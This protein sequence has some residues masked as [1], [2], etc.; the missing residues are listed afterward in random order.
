MS[1]RREVVI[2]SARDGSRV[3]ASILLLIHGRS[4]TYQAGWTSDDGRRT[5]CHNLLLWKGIQLLKSRG[6]L[7]L[8]LG[9]INA[10]HAAGVTK[11]KLGM[12]GTTTKLCGQ[13]S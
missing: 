2:L 3:L 12:G 11:F 8:D 1:P 5:A 4:A 7:D 10:A 13:F 9:G 6:I